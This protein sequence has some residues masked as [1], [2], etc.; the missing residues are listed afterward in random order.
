M[1]IWNGETSPQLCE[2]V[3]S[4]IGHEWQEARISGV[5]TWRPLSLL[6][7]CA[8]LLDSLGNPR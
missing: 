1:V 3:T 8:R 5:M 7:I 2:Q 4:D 6:D